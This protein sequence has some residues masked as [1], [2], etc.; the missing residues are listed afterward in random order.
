MKEKKTYKNE[1]FSFTPE[2]CG[3]SL[4]YQLSGYYDTKPVL[5]IYLIWGK[6]FLYMPWVHYRKVERKKTLKEIRKDKLNAIA[7]KK[8]K[9]VYTKEPYYECDSPQYGIYFYM[10]QFGINLGKKTKLYDLPWAKTWIRTSCLKRDETWEN[11]TKKDNHKEFYDKDKWDGILFSETYPYIYKTNSGEV[12]HC[13]AT[14]R[15]E[16]REWR[17]KWFTWLKWTKKTQKVIDVEFST[18][19]GDRKN[20]WK[21]GCTGCSYEMKLDETP[22]QTLK[23]MEKERRFR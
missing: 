18:D 19:I 14:I 2:W 5:Q 12:Q 11:E 8:V 10:N 7:G 13:S 1:W 20:S 15:V 3:F 9:K 16:E 6:L 4:R 22:L 23:R 17:W 21:G